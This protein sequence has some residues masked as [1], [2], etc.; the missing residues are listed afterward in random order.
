MLKYKFRT[1][2]KSQKPPLPSRKKPRKK[3]LSGLRWNIHKLVRAQIFYAFAHN[4]VQVLF[5]A[6]FVFEDKI[7][8]KA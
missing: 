1:N 2:K 6:A 5:V 4:I 3:E 8:V 7:S